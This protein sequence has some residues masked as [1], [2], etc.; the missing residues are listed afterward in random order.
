MLFDFQAFIDELRE[1]E[2][3][4]E[5]VEK[6]LK[7]FWT[8]TGEIKDQI[9][10]KEYV[11]QFSAISY[12]VPEELKNDFDRDLLMQLVAAS[13]S[14]EGTIDTHTTDGIYEFIITVSSWDK[15]V[16]KKV[17]ELRWFQILKLFEIYAEEQMNLQILMAEDDANKQTEEE[18]N[19]KNAV[20]SQRAAR[21]NRRKLV[22]DTFQKDA[23][24]KQ[25]QEEK[26]NKLTDL[27]GQL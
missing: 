20:L 22:M 1:K 15:L 10:Y 19:E 11:G 13:Y 9:R 26:E 16:T 24:N 25:A 21:I 12:K 3:K 27:Y 5:I 14:S 4:K 17:S 23:L 18:K 2:D 6:Y 7:Y 8:I